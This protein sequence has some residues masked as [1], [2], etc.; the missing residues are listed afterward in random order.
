MHIG[1]RHPHRGCSRLQA[2]PGRVLNL[3]FLLSQACLFLRQHAGRRAACPPLDDRARCV[4][5]HV[6]AFGRYTWMAHV[7]PSRPGSSCPRT[8]RRVW[9][10]YGYIVAVPMLC[11]TAVRAFTTLAHNRQCEPQG[12]RAADDI[13]RS[14]DTRLLN[15]HIHSALGRGGPPVLGRLPPG[16]PVVQADAVLIN[17]ELSYGGAKAPHKAVVTRA[18]TSRPTRS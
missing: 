8:A 5:H 4:A 17:F 15:L 3:S 6:A 2:G 10:K 14:I 13:P 9:K 12:V 11:T 1:S 18:K 16:Y 7:F